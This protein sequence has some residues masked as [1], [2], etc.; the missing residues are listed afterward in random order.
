MAGGAV[1][2]AGTG[3]TAGSAFGPVGTAIGAVAGL[4]GGLFMDAD[5]REREKKALLAQGQQA[6]LQTQASAA[7]NLGQGS[8]S[9]FNAL[10]Q[11]YQ[12]LIR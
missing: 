5:Q 3:A 4:I 12:G 11:N 1:A 8:Q 10:M 7:Q 9:A 2:G 6:A